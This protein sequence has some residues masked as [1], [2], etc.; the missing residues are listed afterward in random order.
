MGL[1]EFAIDEIPRGRY[2]EVGKYRVVEV[3]REGKRC[4]RRQNEG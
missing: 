4:L 1:D 2:L 3:D